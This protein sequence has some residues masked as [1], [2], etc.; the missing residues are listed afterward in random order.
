MKKRP[1]VLV[2][3]AS[4]SVFAAALPVRGASLAGSTVIFDSF[5]PPNMGGFSSGDQGLLTEITV[6]S[7]TRITEFSILN[8]LFQPG[9]LRFALLSYPDPDFLILTAPTGFGQDAPGIPTW[10]S[11]G[12]VDLLLEAGHTYLVGYAHDV[13]LND[14]L[15][16]VS[17]SQNGIESNT[18]LHL[19]DGFEDPSY[20]RLFHSGADGAIRLSVIPEANPC[21]LILSSCL[22]GA[23][24]R[25]RRSVGS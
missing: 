5:T 23:F 2:V 11:S 24:R 22:M 16:Y 1:H 20:D 13:S 14:Y 19:L 3:L 25:R 18:N 17:E 12:P 9:Y 10:K 6:T 8:E 7:D 4:M 15:D 21:L